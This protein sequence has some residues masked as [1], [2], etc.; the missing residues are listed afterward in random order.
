MGAAAP[1]TRC[2][3]KSVAQLEVRTDLPGGLRQ[4]PGSVRRAG[5]LLPL[6]PS[7]AS[8]PGARSSDAGT[9]VPAQVQKEEVTILMG[10]AVPQT[11]WDLPLLF[12]RMDAGLL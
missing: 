9:S 7:P 4:R 12:S 2:S 10:D 6:L 3:S 5:K 8:A 11:P 1:S